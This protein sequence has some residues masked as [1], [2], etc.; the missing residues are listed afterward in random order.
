MLHAGIP[1]SRDTGMESN[2]MHAH[3]GRSNGK[4]TK[5][6]QPDE[7]EPAGLSNDG[8]GGPIP[9]YELAGADST[10]IFRA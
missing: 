8:F 3:T 1:G 2:F 5:G 7:T 4:G 6:V 10:S 9:E